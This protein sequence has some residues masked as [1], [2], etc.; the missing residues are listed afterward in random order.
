MT[1]RENKMNL[2]WIDVKEYNKLPKEEYVDGVVAI[3]IVIKQRDNKRTFCRFYAKHY[4][5]HKPE[6]VCIRNGKITKA[7]HWHPLPK[8]NR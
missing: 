4:K 2:G 5:T 3:Y 7:T 8:I 1:Y 6:F